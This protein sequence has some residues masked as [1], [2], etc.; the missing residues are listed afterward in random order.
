MPCAVPAFIW[1]F[2]THAVRGRDEEKP[3]AS[4]MLDMQPGQSIEAGQVEA[5]ANL[6]AVVSPE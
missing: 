4:V 5:I 3:S 2:Q 6:V 1:R